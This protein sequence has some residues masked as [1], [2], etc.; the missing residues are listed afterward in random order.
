[1]LWKIMKN[2]EEIKEIFTTLRK[3][4]KS[5]SKSIKNLSKIMEKK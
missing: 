2:F 1:M 4:R 5:R 3:N